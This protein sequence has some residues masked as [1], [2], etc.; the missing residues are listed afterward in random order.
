MNHQ[1]RQYLSVKARGSGSTSRLLALESVRLS[2]DGGK[3]TAAGDT[4][5]SIS[6]SETIDG[7]TKGVLAGGVGALLEEKSAANGRGVLASA[8][9]WNGFEAYQRSLKLR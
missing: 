7:M 3:G 1:Q 8:F 2:S 6:D 9:G 4:G 5:S